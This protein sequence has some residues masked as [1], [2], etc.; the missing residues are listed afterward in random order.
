[1]STPN[2][3]NPQNDSLSEVL[4]IIRE[5]AEK[6]AGGDYIYRGEPECFEKVSSSLYRHTD[7]EA[8][9]FDIEIVQKE[10]LNKAKK[11][12][13]EKDEFEILTELQHFGGKTNLIDFTT[14]YLIALFFRLRRLSRQERQN[15]LTKK[16]INRKTY[17]QAS[18]SQKSRHCSEEPVCT[19][20][21]GFS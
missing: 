8:E 4:E 7:I 20:T 16:K 14:D 2:P 21:A 13:H 1:M 10:I 19:T 9:H 17:Q 6:S 3:S 11:Y 18:E 15:Y 12:T 5:I